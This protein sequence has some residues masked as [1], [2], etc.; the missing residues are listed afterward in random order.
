MREKKTYLVDADGGSRRKEKIIVRVFVE[1]FRM[2]KLGLQSSGLLMWIQKTTLTN[3][4]KVVLVWFF[5]FFQ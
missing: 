5:L 3:S 4:L 1:W 2:K